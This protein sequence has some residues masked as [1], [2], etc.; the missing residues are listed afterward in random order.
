MVQIYRAEC[1]ICHREI[2]LPIFFKDEDTW[3]E[4]LVFVNTYGMCPQCYYPNR[5]L[6]ERTF[7]KILIKKIDIPEMF[8]WLTGQK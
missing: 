8:N 2:P 5:E 6:Y 1:M 4:I 3:E 7:I